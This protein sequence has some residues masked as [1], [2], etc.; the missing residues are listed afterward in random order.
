MNTELK[1]YRIVFLNV[2]EQPVEIMAHYFYNDTI[3]GAA[4]FWEYSSDNTG[5]HLV[6]SFPTNNCAIFEIK[7]DGLS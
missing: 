3:L 5:K 7:S 2:D 4:T 6:A 1:R